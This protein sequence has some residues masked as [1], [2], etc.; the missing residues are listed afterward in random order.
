MMSKE[1][2]GSI[3]NNNQPSMSVH[4]TGQIQEYEEIFIVLNVWKEEMYGME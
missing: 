4:Y 1:E 2:R 3:S